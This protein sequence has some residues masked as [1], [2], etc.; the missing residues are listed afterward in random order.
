[1]V[2]S[3]IY[4]TYCSR[5]QNLYYAILVYLYRINKN[6]PNIYIY[7]GIL[8][9]VE[10]ESSSPS[11]DEVFWLLLLMLLGGGLVNAFELILIPSKE[12]R[13]PYLPRS[14]LGILLQEMSLIMY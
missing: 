9:P 8:N 1:M 4:S 6:I 10:E 7:L 12:P 2:L 13:N 5:I 14:I 11:V 3:C